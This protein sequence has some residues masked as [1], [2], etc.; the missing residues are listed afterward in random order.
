M[1]LNIFHVSVSHFYVFI[2]KVAVHIF[3]NFF[4]LIVCFLCI[5]FEKLFVD[6]GYQ[7][8]IC[9]VFGNIFSRSVGCLLVFLTVS[10]AVQ[11]LFI[12]MK[13]I[14]SFFLLFLL[15]LEMCHERS[16]CG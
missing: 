2:G 12:L 11:K 6:L 7:S 8:F 10:L 15:P 1:I 9:S 14:S 13:P 3:C 4:D 5:E 16:C